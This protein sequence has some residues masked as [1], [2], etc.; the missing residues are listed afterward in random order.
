MRLRI[1]KMMSIAY[2]YHYQRFKPDWLK[3]TVHDFKMHCPGPRDF[4][5]PWDCRPNYDY[6]ILDDPAIYD[7]H[8][9]FFDRVDRNCGPF[10]TEQQRQQQLYRLRTDRRFLESLIREMVVIDKPIHE[11]FRILCL[12]AKLDSVLMW[13]HYADK[14][15]GLCLEFGTDNEEFSGAYKVEYCDKYPSYNLTDQS[16]ERNLLPLVTK[17]S[18]WSYEEEYRVIAEEHQVALSAES[19]HAQSSFLSIPSISLKSIILGCEMEDASRNSVRE[20]VKQSG[21]AVAIKQ[22]ERGVGHYSLTISPF[23]LT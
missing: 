1:A 2:L 20:I 18:V 11:Q 23:P 7:E 6:S 16:L 4:N 5:D 3:T 8:V 9:A 22:A 10:K 17:S 21:R 12:S 19:L 14:H 15:R 13:S